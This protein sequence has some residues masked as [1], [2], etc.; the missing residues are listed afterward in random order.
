MMLGSKIG[1]V[2]AEVSVVLAC[3]GAIGRMICWPIIRFFR[4]M[5]HAVEYV[6]SEMRFN[7][8]STQRDAIWRIESRLGLIDDAL[9]IETPDYLLPPEK[10]NPKS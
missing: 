10:E 1:E 2:A 9:Q 6:E 3:A 8:G 4:R 5:G 7:S